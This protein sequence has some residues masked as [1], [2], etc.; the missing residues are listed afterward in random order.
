[1]SGVLV[2]DKTA[3]ITEV[4]HPPL[5]FGL[6]FSSAPFGD[7]DITD[8]GPE[9]SLIVVASAS[10]GHAGLA[11]ARHRPQ[12][13]DVTAARAWRFSRDVPRVMKTGA[14]LLFALR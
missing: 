2:A 1:M 6:I 7:G 3:S 12:R 10:R 8:F 5:R 13:C 11:R 9:W 14:V 4:A